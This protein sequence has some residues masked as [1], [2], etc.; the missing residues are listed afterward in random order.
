MT[1]GIIRLRV[2]KAKKGW[3]VCAYRKEGRRWIQIGFKSG[4]RT[5][6]A[7]SKALAEMLKEGR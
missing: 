7:A 4:Y 5:E 2:E 3:Q 6:L 1:G